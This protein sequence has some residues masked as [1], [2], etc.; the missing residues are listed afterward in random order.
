M[1]GSKRRYR[2]SS[3]DIAIIAIWAGFIWDRSAISHGM[4]AVIADSASLARTHLQDAIAFAGEQRIP[5]EVVQT[6]EMERPEYVRNDAARCFHCKDELFIVMERFAEEHDFHSIA[7]GVNVDDQGD[8]RP[9]QMAARN[10]RVAAP[11]LEAGL[12]KSDIRELARQAGL[13]VWEKPASACLSS[14]IEY[15]R[16]VTSEAL[17]AVEKGEDALRALGFKQFLVR[18]HGQIARIDIPRD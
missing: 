9:G 15:G 12:T 7:Y 6:Q 13:R 5:L 16:P 8:F 14:R 2:R 1:L 11:L 3:Q 10:H 4:L 17:T 18:H